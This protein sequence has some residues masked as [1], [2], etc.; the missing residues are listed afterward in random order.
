MDNLPPKE[1]TAQ[2]AYRLAHD[3][4]RDYGYCPQCVLAALQETTDIGITEELIQATF[5]AAGGGALKGKGTCG[6]LLG[7]ILALGLNSGRKRSQFGKKT[8]KKSIFA[9]KELIERFEKHFG[10]I[11]CND[12]Q[13]HFTGRIF[14][15]WNSDETKLFGQT[16]CKKKK[17]PEIAGSV[18]KWTIELL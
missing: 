6:A 4:D 14:D 15:M 1:E 7:G 12:V 9:A 13:M 17:C 3:Y 2:K 16:E 8:S 10:G 11:S 18:A 5:P